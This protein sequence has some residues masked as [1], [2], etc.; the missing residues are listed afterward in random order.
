MRFEGKIDALLF[1]ARCVF[2][3]VSVASFHDAG[4]RDHDQQ[5]VRSARREQSPQWLAERCTR[6]DRRCHH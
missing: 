4:E 5:G 6:S 1:K 3:S 2:F